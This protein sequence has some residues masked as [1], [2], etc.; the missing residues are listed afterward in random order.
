MSSRHRSK[1]KQSIALGMPKSKRKRKR[2]SS[3]LNL[4]FGMIACAIL[5]VFSAATVLYYASGG[6]STGKLFQ[7]YKSKVMSPHAAVAGVNARGQQNLL[8]GAVQKKATP[9]VN[10]ANM[11]AAKDVG[12]GVEK[13][14]HEEVHEKAAQ[15][16]AVVPLEHLSQ[17]ALDM[18]TRTLWHTLE[19]TTIVLPN[20]ETFIHTGDIDDLWLRDSASQIHPLLIPVHSRDGG[21]P[22]RAL[23]YDDPKLDRIV[24]GLIARHALY[25]RHDPY[26]NAF[27]IDDSYVFS[28]EQ[29]RMGRH[30]LISTWNYELDSACFTI[31]MIYYY[32]KQSRDPQEALVGNPAVQEAVSI[33][34]DLWIAEQEHE[35]DKYPTGSLFDCQN[36]NKPYRYPGLPRDGKGTPTNATAG[37]TWTGFR[38]SDDECHYGYLIPANMFAVVAL[39]YV[40]ELSRELW[41]NVEIE[42]KAATLQADIRRGIEEHGVVEHSTFGKI[43]AYEVDGLGTSLLMDDANVPSLLSIPYLDYPYN[44]EIYANTRRFILSKDNPEYSEGTNQLTGPVAGIGSPHMKARIKKNVWPMAMA[45]QALTTNDNAEA[46]HLVEQLVQATAGTGWMH[47]SFDVNNPKTFTRSWFCWADSLY[48][49]LVL[50]LLNNGSSDSGGAGSCPDPNRKYKVLEWRDPVTVKG[51]VYASVD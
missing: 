4:I 48:A 35:L 31:R 39:G 13:L 11:V 24:S 5:T 30:D 44:E 26:A 10:R 3:P 27:R 16:Q 20:K 25:I 22:K 32:W 7:Q 14:S 19:S 47:E 23:I 46:H 41:H 6:G 1:E 42:R 15:E 9:A 40:Q 29:K 21:G 50:R 18:C 2:Q 49:E 33:M 45:M 37:L 28:E 34:V 38:P 17:A 51:G 43:Y 36:C 8:R 12:G